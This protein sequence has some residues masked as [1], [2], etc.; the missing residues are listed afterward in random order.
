MI[1]ERFTWNQPF[2]APGPCFTWNGAYEVGCCDAASRPRGRIARFPSCPPIAAKVISLHRYASL[3][4]RSELRAAIL[5]SVIGRMPIGITGLAVLLMAQVETGSFAQ[6]G[7]L[8]AAYV[9]GLATFAPLLGRII[10]R[11]GP[12]LVLTASAAA[13]PTA[14][15]ALVAATHLAQSTSLNL[16]L[17][18][19]AG[20]SFPPI[21]VCMRTFF[22]QRLRDEALL[23]A[24]YSLEAV[25]IELIFIA[26]PMLVALLVAIATPAAAVLLAALCGASGTVLFLR[27]P[28]LAQWRMEPRSGAG[29]LGPLAERG[30]PALLAVV[31]GYSI[32]FGLVE[33][34]ITAYAAARGHPAV[35]GVLLALMS[36]GSALGGLA[37]GSRSWSPPLTRQFAIA[38]ALMGAGLALLAPSTNLWLFTILSFFAGIVMAPALTM[39]SMLVARTASAR[40][41]TEAF[42][43]SSTGLLSGVA[44][45]IAVGGWLIEQWTW[46]AVFVAASVCAFGSAALALGLRPRR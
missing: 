25:L 41:A 28:A 36:A 27:S 19:I 8:T 15:C 43:W 42:T 26:G 33:I 39:Q 32:A 18:F 35:A 6:G 14:L 12:R 7:A 2:G 46:S 31:L 1:R 22:R 23:G 38:L 13:F 20:A 34:G 21:T 11:S 10:D 4:A 24:A 3:L 16:V 17:G 40:H 44:L 9:L 29:L 37:Y 5:A 45:G 30:F